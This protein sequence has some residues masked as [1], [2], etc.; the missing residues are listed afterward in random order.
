MYVHSEG[1]QQMRRLLV[2]AIVVASL[3]CTAAVPLL[4]QQGTSEVS[5]RITDEQGGAMPGVSV[6]LTNEETGAFRD[7]MTGTDG[8]FSAP[9]LNRGA[10]AWWRSCRTSARSREAA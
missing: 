7:V 6:T 9:Q 5:G 2:R 4:A 8:S 10:T 1:R 3:L